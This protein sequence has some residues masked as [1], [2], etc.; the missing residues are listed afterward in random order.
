MHV[1][2]CMK[3][4]ANSMEDAVKK[5]ENLLTKYS[6][7]ENE[8]NHEVEL[9]PRDFMKMVDSNSEMDE[10]Q[11]N[12]Y[13]ELLEDKTTLL[14]NLLKDDEFDYC[15][16]LEDL[17]IDEKN[18]PT[19]FLRLI[20]DESKNVFPGYS[21]KYISFGFFDDNPEDYIFVKL[22][23]N[24][25]GEKR[26]YLTIPYYLGF[27]YWDYSYGVTDSFGI[28]SDDRF[29][30]F[31]CCGNDFKNINSKFLDVL[32]SDELNETEEH[33]LRGMID[34]Y[35]DTNEELVQYDDIDEKRRY[36]TD[37]ISNDT[38]FICGSV[39]T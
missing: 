10:D 32:F 29:R 38:Y 15:D 9:L 33:W 14:K 13:F 3:I 20:I 8:I 39:H 31:N 16:T 12:L 6:L 7:D 35:L 11:I 5:A 37:E 22:G 25:E 27:G 26:I 36:F 4:H 23:E 30:I 18:N 2:V 1:G 21:T 17:E 28:R 19:P 34:F 24:S